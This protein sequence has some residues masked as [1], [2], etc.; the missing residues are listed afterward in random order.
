MPNQY[1]IDPAVLKELQDWK[2]YRDSFGDD[3]AKLNAAQQADPNFAAKY[4]GDTLSPGAKQYA[5][6]RYDPTANGGKGGPAAGTN[7]MH[8]DAQTGQIVKNKG[9]FDLPETWGILGAAAGLGGVVAAPAIAGLFG[10]GGAASAAAPAATAA[11]GG[12]G[13]GTT[14]ATVAGGAAAAGKAGGIASWLT[15]PTGSLINAGISTAGN[16]VGGIKE[17]NAAKEAAALQDKQFQQAL[18]AQKEQ[19]QFNRNQYGAYLGRLQGYADTGNASNARL[20]AFMGQGR[21]PTNTEGP[22]LHPSATAPAA[23]PPSSPG[24]TMAAP[25]QPPPQGAPMGQQAQTVKMVGPDG[26]FRDI[27]ADQVARFQQMG[28]KVAQQAGA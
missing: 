27:P 23:V 2:A 12:A 24:G 8:F 25:F 26:S 16:I 13:A 21:M 17:A 19:E 11:T 1:S 28:A 4:N 5:V 15:G 20:A 9:A 18:D 10:G 22:P 14:A 3:P 7:G 6:G